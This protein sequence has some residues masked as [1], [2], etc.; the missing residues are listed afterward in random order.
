MKFHLLSKGVCSIV[1]LW[2]PYL[3]YRIVLDFTVPLLLRECII[4]LDIYNAAVYLKLSTTNE[5]YQEMQKSDITNY[6]EKTQKTL[7]LGKN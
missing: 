5:C 7:K 2:R 6:K 3:Y 4:V 1:T